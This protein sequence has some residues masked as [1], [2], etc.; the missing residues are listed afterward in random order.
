MDDGKPWMAI[1]F[2][3]RRWLRHPSFALE[4]LKAILVSPLYQANVVPLLT[5]VAEV[6]YF[7]FPCLTV[8]KE[9]SFKL[10]LSIRT[11]YEV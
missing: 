4:E 7:V 11:L 9:G 3:V 2:A 8:H 5:C 1:I 6:A 10:K